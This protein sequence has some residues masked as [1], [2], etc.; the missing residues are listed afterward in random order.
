MN[1]NRLT[2]K[3]YVDNPTGAKTAVIS[4]RKMYEDL[5]NDKWKKIMTRE[6]GK[7]DYELY[8]NNNEYYCYLKIPS[9]NIDNFYYDVVIKMEQDGKQH[10]ACTALGTNGEAHH[11]RDLRGAGDVA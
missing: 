4:Y 8:Y 1:N 10:Q 9:E 3:Q 7:I 6:V 11:Q 2:F 5:Y